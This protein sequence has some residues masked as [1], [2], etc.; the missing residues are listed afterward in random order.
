M[1]GFGQSRLAAHFQNAVSKRRE[2]FGLYAEI[3]KKLQ[4]GETGRVLDIG[5]GSG[6][7]LKSIHTSHPLFELFGIDL[8]TEAIKIG[9]ENL[10]GIEVNLRA[11]RIEKTSFDDAYFDLVTCHSSMSYWKNLILCFDEIHRILK[12]GGKAVLF[13]PRKNIDIDAAVEIIQ[14]RLENAGKLRRFFAINLNKYGLRWGSK[15]GLRLYSM[16]ELERIIQASRFVNQV[17][18]EPETLQ[19]IPIFMKIVLQKKDENPRSNQK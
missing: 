14:K 16:V 8:S 9:K 2:E 11:E 17:S 18:I 1:P 15:L 3:T 7:Q 4:L 12:P 10:A 19:D 13:E 5:T 6:L